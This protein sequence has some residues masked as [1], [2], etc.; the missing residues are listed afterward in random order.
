MLTMKVT[1]LDG[2]LATV[3]VIVTRVVAAAALE[4]LGKGGEC[5][6]GNDVHDLIDLVDGS[7]ALVDDQK[8]QYKAAQYGM[9]YAYCTSQNSWQGNF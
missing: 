8:S 2:G 1:L 5:S 3:T 4:V 7:P 9:N 6:K